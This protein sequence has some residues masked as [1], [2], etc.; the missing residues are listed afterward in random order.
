MRARGDLAMQLRLLLRPA[1]V[2]G[3][4][5]VVGGVGM[6]LAAYLSWYE[7]H[8]DVSAL[9][10]TQGTTVASLA[11]WEAQPWG[12]AV[13]AV[14]LVAVVVSLRVALDR[15]PAVAAE[16]QLGAGL[17]VAVLTGVSALV[18]PPVS[19]FD[20]AGT[21]LREVTELAGG[22]PSDVDVAFSVR[23]DEGLWVALAAAAL[24]VVAGA[25]TR[26]L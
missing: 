5:G 12:W 6:F 1:G 11:G 26:E 23:P 15:P 7:V 18:F 19:R 3:A 21:R 24:L 17:T 14:A 2:I 9:G 10:H 22:L 8:A 25:V 4:V 16:V 20:V 13:P